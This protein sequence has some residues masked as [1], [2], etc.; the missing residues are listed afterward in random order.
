MTTLHLSLALL[1]SFPLSGVAATWVSVG[2][3]AEI[4][5]FVDTDSIRKNG[6]LVKTWLKWQWTKPS[7]I[8]N[9]YPKKFYQTEKQLQISDCANR[10]LAVAQGIYYA[11]TNGTN[12]VDSYTIEERHWQ[13]SEAAPETIGETLIK[14]ACRS[15]GAKKK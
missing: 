9:S 5:V 13:F 14:F 10:T 6:N 12:V 2:E 7:E 4:E 15:Q 8:P 1:L 3:N 11:D